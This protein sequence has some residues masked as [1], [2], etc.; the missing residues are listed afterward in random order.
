MCGTKDG[1][2]EAASTYT[3]AG[4]GADDMLNSSG[5]IKADTAVMAGLAKLVQSLCCCFILL[6]L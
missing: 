3:A 2:V 4:A 5:T 6:A 1:S